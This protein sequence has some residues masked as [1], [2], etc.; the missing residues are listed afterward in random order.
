[1]QSLQAALHPSQND[2]E[3]M[4]GFCDCSEKLS[5]KIIAE[6]EDSCHTATMSKCSLSTMN[7]HHILLFSGV[8]FH[9][10][11]MVISV[12]SN[13]NILWQQCAIISLHTSRSQVEVTLL[14]CGTSGMRTATWKWLN[15][16]VFT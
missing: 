5:K 6:A 15:F 10:I 11:S 9:R 2:I 3:E 12:F 4:A 14:T 7:P 13:R 16:L 1:M 8:F